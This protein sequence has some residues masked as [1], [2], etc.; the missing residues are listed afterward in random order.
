MNKFYWASDYS[1]IR[2]EGG[3]FYYGYERILCN[4]CGKF[5]CDDDDHAWDDDK[6]QEWCFVATLGDVETLIPFSQLTGCKDMF[7]VSECLMGGIG[8][9]LSVCTISLHE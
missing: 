1:G 2:F 5:D 6:G 9:F 7:N 3:E 8:L 4:V